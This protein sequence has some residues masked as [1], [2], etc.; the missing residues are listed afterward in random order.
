MSK[1]ISVNHGLR[2]GY[3]LSPTVFNNFTGN[4]LHTWKTMTNPGIQM[5]NLYA[6]NQIV[7]KKM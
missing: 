4:M 3:G 6:D 1:E 2:L 7:L 5:N